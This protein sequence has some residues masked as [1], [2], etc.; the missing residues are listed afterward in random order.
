M[1]NI[2]N[3]SCKDILLPFPEALGGSRAVVTAVS[4]FVESK[5][6]EQDN[7]LMIF[8][9][10]TGLDSIVN[11][12]FFVGSESTDSSLNSVSSARNDKISELAD[13]AFAVSCPVVITSSDNSLFFARNF[14]CLSL[15]SKP[16]DNY[17]SFTASILRRCVFATCTI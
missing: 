7:L 10:P 12:R 9:A 4:A 3:K 6:I 14:G 11:I 8:P 17:F 5:L 16:T 2:S 13:L 1:C 15:N